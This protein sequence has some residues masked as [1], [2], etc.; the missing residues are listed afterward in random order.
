MSVC[1]GGHLGRGKAVGSSPLMLLWFFCCCCYGFWDW[2]RDAS[3]FVVM[4]MARIGT[5]MEFSIQYSN[6]I[7]PNFTSIRPEGTTTDGM[8]QVAALSLLLSIT[9]PCEIRE[10]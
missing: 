10:D 4:Y 7:P 8:R 2:L 3:C 6:L 5:V 9:S 1:L